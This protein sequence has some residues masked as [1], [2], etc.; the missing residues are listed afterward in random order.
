M[1]VAML[2]FAAVNSASASAVTAGW[3]LNGTLLKAEGL[4][5]A[6]LA[7][8]VIVDEEFE[9]NAGGGLQVECGGL[10]IDNGK[11]A[12]PND[13][14]VEHLLFNNCKTV[15]ANCTVPTAIATVAILAEV[16]LDGVL[17]VKGVAKPETGTTFATI[18]YSGELCSIAGIKA[19]TGDAEVLGDEGQDEHTDQ[20]ILGVQSAAGKLLFFS[21]NPA[22]FTGAGLVLL[23][24]SKP[25]SFL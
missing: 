12:D 23:A 8:E 21:S 24:N 25:W 16:T 22:S 7:T 6:A 15:T 11:I 19:A 18:K 17:H 9:L 3:M 20:L 4:T 2:A 14:L 1:F 13:L 5:S 10:L